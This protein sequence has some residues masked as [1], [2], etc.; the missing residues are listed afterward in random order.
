MT[1]ADRSAP[2]GPALK[3]Y[4][5]ELERLKALCDAIPNTPM[6]AMAKVGALV[7]VNMRYERV[8][9]DRNLIEHPYDLVAGILRDAYAYVSAWRDS[10]F[11]EE[12][13]PPLAREPIAME[14]R[15]EDLF[16]QLWTRF[17]D[18][19]YEDRIARY[20]HRLRINGL[21]A[22]WMDGRRCIDFGCGHG[23]FAHALLRAGAG[24]VYGLDFGSHSIEY[25][26]RAR[27][28]LGVSPSRLEFAVG[29]VYDVAQPDAAFDFVI[30]NGVFHHLDD[31]DRAIA[32]VWRVLKPGGWFWVYTDG[33]GAISHDLWDASVHILRGVPQSFVLQCLDQLH[34]QTGKRYHLGDGLNAPYRHTTWAALTARLTRH[35]F[36]NFRRLVGGFDTDFDHDAIAADRYGPE[37]FGEGDLRCLAMKL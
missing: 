10:G 9:V 32:E 5:P 37:K 17:N 4:L 26:I 16:Q 7:T 29:S 28:R 33:S 18:R 13:G 27:D 3:T 35:G 34:L 25:A 22:A 23:N 6:Q 30:Q 24:Y 12:A 8:M 11:A 31:E 36:G 21:D 2:A 20:V 14:A 19:E 15:H 1:I